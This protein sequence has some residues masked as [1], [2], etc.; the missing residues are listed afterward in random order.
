MQYIYEFEIYK[1]TKDYIVKPFDLEGATQG[2]SIEDACTSAYDWLKVSLENYAINNITPPKATF[3]NKPKHKGRILIFGVDAGK[4]T[5]NRVSASEASR[6]LGVSP[7]RITQLAK[8]NKLETFKEGGTVW[9]TIDSINQR[10][11]D[12]PSAG[13]PKSDNQAVAV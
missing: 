5:V 6:M 11:K 8:N 13:R 12:A 2:T 7:A 4:E 10:L 9:V 3:E 1:G